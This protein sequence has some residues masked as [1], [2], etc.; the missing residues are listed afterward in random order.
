VT[1]SSAVGLPRTRI[2]A[3]LASGGGGLILLT[4][5]LVA[6]RGVFSLADI[7]LLY[8]IPVV[9]AAVIGGLW[10]ALPAALA[11]DLV[12]NFFF[13]PPYYT[14]IVGNTEHVIVLFTYVLIALAISL[15]VDFAARQRAQAARRETEARLLAR[16]NTAPV[17]E[18]SLTDLLDDIKDT[19][20]MTGVA[21]LE[22]RATG[23]EPVASVGTV[24]QSRPVLSAPAGD[25]LRLVAWGPEVF[26]QDAAALRRMAGVTART[27]EA[28]RLAAE[29]ARIDDLA[30]IDRARSALLAAVGHDLRTPLA[31]IKVAASSLRQSDA[32]LPRTR[33]PNSS[34]PSRSRPT[35]SVSWSTTFWT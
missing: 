8:L 33:R 19:F 34:P 10:A 6:V 13:V 24:T 21:L 26:G 7:V 2:W 35:R 18:A 31:G 20:G 3:G 4:V 17:G 25:S 28:Q 12:V 14:L 22:S 15:A 29:A 27:L 11:A 23:E 9:L 1:S 32:T 30:R 16:A 5:G